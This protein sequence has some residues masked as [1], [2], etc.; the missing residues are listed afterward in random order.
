MTQPIATID[1]PIF[2]V[3]PPLAGSTVLLAMLQQSPSVLTINDGPILDGVEALQPAAREFD[4]NRLTE[5]DATPETRELVR[6]AFAQAAGG[7]AVRLLAASPKNSLRVAFLSEVLPDS[8]F[9]YLYRDPRATINNMLDAW[10]SG[11]FIT[12][13]NLPGWYNL[14]WS[15]VLTPEWRASID[16]PLAEIVARQW[17]TATTILLDDLESL[18]PERW[19]V[20]G[21]REIIEDPNKEVKRLCRFVDIALTGELPR[22]APE[23]EEV[24][25]NA[26]ELDTIAPFIRAT[27][28]R[29][30]DL[31]ATP[32]AQRVRRPR[33]SVVRTAPAAQSQAAQAATPANFTSVFTAAFPQILNALG[34]SVIVSTY[35]SGRVVILRA[36]D[37]ATLNT[38]FRALVSPMGIAVGPR[39]MAIGTQREIFDYRNQPELS[40]RLEP[41][42]K[43]D[44][45]FVPRNVH[46]TGD[47]RIH[48]VGFASNEL[49]VVNTRFSTLCTIDTEHSFVPRWR[50]KFVSHLAPEDR[51]HLNGMTIIDDRIRYVTALGATNTPQGWRETKA[52]GGILI[53]VE[54]GEIV[55]RGLSMPHS[56]RWYAGKF[57]ILESG[58]GTFGTLDL[59]SGRVETIAELPGFTR[60][61]AFAGPYA[62]VGLS[63]VRETNVFGG[64][65]LVERVKD[66]QCGVWVIDLRSGQVA[67]FL[68][69][70]GAVQEI[71]DV[72]VLHGIRYPELL[73]PSSE[74]L[75]TSYV[76]PQAAMADV[77]NA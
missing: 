72:Q 48:E 25:R 47:I 39:S 70:Q 16:K 63:Q 38:H 42:G 77:A 53:D 31:F 35:Q 28:D 4:S 46:Y 7:S 41:P 74:L 62:F 29:A 52:T 32:P 24:S 6:R 55:A 21:Y 12:Y 66:R 69:F 57:W 5:A 76:L 43:H 18:P 33:G 1:R 71:F 37:D 14:P 68:Q 10:R 8:Y 54:S 56:P 60:G 36:D 59:A 3:A 13:P 67:A 11:R 50:P 23:A 30:R 73:E 9:I 20:A 61:L 19:C 65:Q 2:I 49:W 34:A 27:A 15:L 45:C 22:N 40:P 44:A 17:D 64:I 75:A 58:R 26:A 51:C